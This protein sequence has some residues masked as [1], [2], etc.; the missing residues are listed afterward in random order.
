MAGWHDI[1]K[2]VQV[3][4]CHN[5]D[6]DSP[7]NKNMSRIVAFLSFLSFLS[8]LF[9]KASLWLCP[10]F[11]SS[12]LPLT[13]ARFQI[14]G[15]CHAEQNMLKPCKAC[16]KPCTLRHQIQ[17]DIYA[18]SD[19]FVYTCFCVETTRSTFQLKM[20]QTFGFP[21]PSATEQCMLCQ[22]VATRQGQPKDLF[23]WVAYLSPSN[24]LSPNVGTHE[25]SF[26]KTKKSHCVPL[27]VCVHSV[28]M[29]RSTTGIAVEVCQPISWRTTNL[30]MGFVIF[31]SPL[32]LRLCELNEHLALHRIAM[33]PSHLVRP[34]AWPHTSANQP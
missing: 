8:F 5:F 32:T 15:S 23:A 4:Y 18:N 20:R 14:A 9:S 27:H 28:E 25:I 29:C 26:C 7:Q 22:S 11:S 13:L 31:L 21:I 30:W 1:F 34:S 33:Q 12:H 2:L 24:G 10:F 6:I 3:S 19:I 16:W 17:Q